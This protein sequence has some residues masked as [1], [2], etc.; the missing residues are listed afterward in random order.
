MA[1]EVEARVVVARKV[2]D[3]FHEAAGVTENL[4]RFF[5]GYGGLIPGIVSASLDGDGVMRP[6]ALRTVKLSDGSVIKERVTRFEAPRV[7]AYDMAEMNALQRLICTNMISEWTFA[8]EG[9]ATRVVWHYS[10]IPRNS[11]MTPVAW[12]VSRLFERAMQRCLDN[13]AA[14]VR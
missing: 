8:D 1:I 6:G 3:V 4:A 9:G 7:H 10:I 11:V 13:L 5:K 14:A 12:L 2:E